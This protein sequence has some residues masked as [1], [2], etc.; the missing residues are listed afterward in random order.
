MPNCGFNKVAKQLYWNHTSAWVF[1]CKFAAYFQN[2]VS[3]EELLWLLLLLRS[4]HSGHHCRMRIPFFSNYFHKKVD[5]NLNTS[6]WYKLQKQQSCCGRELLEISQ[7]SQKN[8]R[9]G[10][11]EGLQLSTQ[12]FN[13]TPTQAFSCE[14]CRI[15]KNIYFEEHL[16]TTPS[17]IKCNWQLS[18]K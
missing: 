16:R 3:W 6:L 2:T 9:V 5:R 4:C 13:T 1:S 14:Y 10:V 15:F 12:A 18:I 17:V 11:S 7:Y 8:N